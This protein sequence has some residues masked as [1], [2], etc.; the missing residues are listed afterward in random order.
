MLKTGARSWSNEA[1]KRGPSTSWS[2]P[3]DAD[4]RAAHVALLARDLARQRPLAEEVHPDDD[5]VDTRAEVVDVRHHD[6]PDAPLTKGVERPGSAKRLEEVAVARSVERRRPASVAKELAGRLEPER[7]E[8]VE[9][10]RLSEVPLDDVRADRLVRR[11]ARHQRHRNLAP[12]RLLEPR[13]LP[14]FAS[15]KL[16]PST[17]VE[18]GL[19]DTAEARRHAAGEDDLRDLAPLERVEPRRSRARRTRASPGCRQLRDVVV[20]RRL[21]RARDDVRGGRELA[22]GD[23]RAQRLEEVLVEAEALEDRRGLAIDVDHDALRRSAGS[24]D[25]YGARWTP[26]SVT[27]AVTSVGGSD[28]ERRVARREARRDLARV[29]LLDRDV[30]AGRSGRHRP[31]RSARRRRTG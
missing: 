6:D 18:D 24:E 26:T 29:A 3:V 22:R 11:E 2:L 7:D 14:S 21:D 10:E 19:D 5:R 8:L 4:R 27:I 12:E 16:W 31:S 15:R 23:P 20:A 28:V 17:A 30:R 1:G 13:G 25:A 9:H